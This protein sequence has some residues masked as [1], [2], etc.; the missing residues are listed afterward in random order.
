MYSTAFKSKSIGERIV[1]LAHRRARLLRRRIR[2]HCCLNR[3]HD[4][5]WH[6]NH[7]DQLL[8]RVRPRV[9]RR[10]AV[11]VTVFLFPMD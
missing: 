5:H 2:R 11:P 8:R 6:R 7:E 10:L 9:V 4:G 1:R 3:H